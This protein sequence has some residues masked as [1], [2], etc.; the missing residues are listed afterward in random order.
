MGKLNEPSMLAEKE[1][2][3]S[4]VERWVDKHL[5]GQ[6]TASFSASSE[7]IRQTYKYEK[8]FDRDL[9]KEMNRLC[10]TE[11]ERKLEEM[12]GVTTVVEE[13]PQLVSDSLQ[14]LSSEL[15][16]IP[17][18]PAYDLALSMD[19]VYI[20]S[21]KFRL[22]FLRRTEFD[23]PQAASRLLGFFRVQHEVWG[24]D[25]VGK[26]IT[27][28]DM[29]DDDL[30]CLYNGHLQFL[31]SRDRGGRVVLFNDLRYIKYADIMNQLRV[32]W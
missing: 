17:V 30:K 10:V 3:W 19:R 24:E 9:A 23:A 8:D 28:A 7:P 13:T 26:E 4:H 29:S 22:M 32:Y 6:D 31:Q 15:E 11:R 14:R 12:H 27:Q 25:K 16:N 1:D 2:E 18:K 21:P 20:E 5:V